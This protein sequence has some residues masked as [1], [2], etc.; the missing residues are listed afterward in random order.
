MVALLA[1]TTVSLGAAVAMSVVAW[2]LAREE[3]TRSEARVAALAA[4]IHGTE[5]DRAEE[6][7]AVAVNKLFTGSQ[8]ALNHGGA[9]GTMAIGVLA[10]GSLLAL[11]T[12][13][14]S[15]SP[16]QSVATPVAETGALVDDPPPSEP[17]ELIALGHD[18]VGDRLTVRGVVRSPSRPSL[19]GGLTAVVY[20]FDHQGSFAASAR[21]P[22]TSAAPGGASDV[23]STFSVTI[24]GVKDV[25][26]YR[27]SF[28][29][30]DQTV[31]HVDRRDAGLSSH[32]P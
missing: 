21:A 2:R 25:H 8:A 14:T 12:A 24:A 27:I 32:L 29:N 3:R 19:D 17:L 28:R 4:E 6:R 9:L 10:V 16:A 7:S 13:F 11:A 15:G 5:S 31:A 23:E 26:R 20:V 30:E 22:L 18:R 1:V